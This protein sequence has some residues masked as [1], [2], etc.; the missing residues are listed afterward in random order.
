MIKHKISWT[1]RWGSSLS[2]S[3]FLEF[4]F[5]ILAEGTLL[6]KICNHLCQLVGLVFWVNLHIAHAI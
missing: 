1:M 3:S 4:L 6:L 5:P 2:L